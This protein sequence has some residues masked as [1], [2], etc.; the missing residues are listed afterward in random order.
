MEDIFGPEPTAGT[1][2]E[3]AASET[4]NNLEEFDDIFG[5]ASTAAGTAEGEGVGGS[6]S[7]QAKDAPAAPAAASGGSGLDEFDDIFGGSE[8]VDAAS[9]EQQHVADNNKAGETEDIGAG[10]ASTTTDE[11]STPAAAGPGATAAADV[12]GGKSGAGG[13]KEFLD[14][15]YDGDGAG[16]GE[17][18]SEPPPAPARSSPPGSAG[19]PSGRKSPDSNSTLGEEGSFLEIPT[20]VTSPF[21]APE[22]SVEPTSR[23]ES[24]SLEGSPLNLP[25]A[26]EPTAASAA[27]SE[28][29]P[30][31]PVPTTTLET[32]VRKEKAEV[33][34]PLPDDPAAALREIAA[35]G[36]QA[37]GDGGDSQE[38]AT[39]ADAA[40][41][42]GYVR[43]LCAAT[44]GF[45]PPDLR[46]VVW[47]LLLGRGRRPSDAGFVKWRARRREELAAGAAA[48]APAV[49]YKLDLRNDCLALARRLCDDDSVAGEDD[50]GGAGDGASG[51]GEGAKKDPEALAFDIE[52]VCLWACGLLAFRSVFCFCT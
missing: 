23:L 32:Y 39:A 8:P 6:S 20:T 31:S 22:G 37:T 18:A 15:L 41:D 2:D 52:E 3:A 5:D 51:E 25:I 14:F 17:A 47:G 11:N 35:P 50:G 29:K 27:S 46:P 40:D 16:S 36:V 43:R 38:E 45:L 19:S 9:E 42:V 21:Q 12:T 44:G 33:L 34:R 7:E 30:S 49:S 24:G 28:P 13:D 4:D 10:G 1:P 26:E 48:D